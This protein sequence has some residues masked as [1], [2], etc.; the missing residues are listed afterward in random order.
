MFSFRFVSFYFVLFRSLAPVPPPFPLFTGLAPIRFPLVLVRAPATAFGDARG[1]SLIGRE[2]RFV[3]RE[4][5]RRGRRNNTVRASVERATSLCA[6]FPL[7]RSLSVRSALA[8]SAE[9][10]RPVRD[11]SETLFGSGSK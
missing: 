3:L 10:S 5:I 4:Q 6:Y 11:R 8:P 7:F 1:A 9:F 2:P